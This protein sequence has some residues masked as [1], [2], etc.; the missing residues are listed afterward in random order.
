MLVAQLLLRFRRALK[1]VV[2]ATSRTLFVLPSLVGAESDD[3]EDD[4]CAK[5][6]VERVAG[7]VAGL[8]V[9]GD[10]ERERSVSI[11]QL[12]GSEKSSP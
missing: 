7:P 8:S 3:P 5:G 4:D 11:M 9:G 6:D 12:G 1:P 2:P 10:C